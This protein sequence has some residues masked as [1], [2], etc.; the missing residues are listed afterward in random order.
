MASKPNAWT[1]KKVRYGDDLEYDDFVVKREDG[2]IVYG[3]RPVSQGKGATSSYNNMLT[4]DMGSEVYLAR[5]EFL[6][7]G[8]HDY[9]AHTGIEVLYMLDGRLKV[10]YRS[11]DDRDVTAE[12]KAG[13]MAYFPSGTPHAVWNTSSELCHFIV[14]KHGPPYHFEEI[15]LPLPL[16]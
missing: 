7:G 3:D 12:C 8:G 16:K 9:H 2:V 14:V 10:T 5:I 11:K 4:R 15:P 1:T 13:D 6:P